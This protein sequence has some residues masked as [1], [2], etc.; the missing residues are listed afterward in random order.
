MEPDQDEIVRL[1]S[2]LELRVLI[3]LRELGQATASQLAD[4]LQDGTTPSTVQVLLLRMEKKEVVS[5]TK[6]HGNRLW[7][8]ASEDAFRSAIKAEARYAVHIRYLG[9]A[10]LRAE[11]EWQFS[12]CEWTAKSSTARGKSG[13][14]R[15]AA[16]KVPEIRMLRAFCRRWKVVELAEIDP[17]LSSNGEEGTRYC[18]ASFAAESHWG[19]FDLAKVDTQL[20]ELLGE[21]A[22]L[23]SRAAVEA[24]PDWTRR[25]QVLSS[26]QGLFPPAGK[27]GRSV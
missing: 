18:I 24:D 21:R 25:R 20:S 14:G 12:T 2:D 1:L 27:E 5:S 23:V 22:H 11:L 6:L 8:L 15:L 19:L 16:K 4:H 7:R 26:L 3:V 10:L 13:A 17:S 9:S